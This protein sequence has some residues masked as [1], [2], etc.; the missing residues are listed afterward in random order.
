MAVIQSVVDYE[1][2]EEERKAAAMTEAQKLEAEKK[3][4][5]EER[6]AFE[7]QQ[8]AFVLRQATLGAA[9]RAGAIYP[10]V[11]DS[12]VLSRVDEVQFN[13]AREPQNVD[14]L[15]GA[16][17]KTH[18]YLFRAPAGSADGGAG[19][20]VAGRPNSGGMNEIIRRAAGRQG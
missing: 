17:R 5:E 15:V 3:R 2:A 16:I 10:D 11:I 7:H 20:G 4:L 1:K 18:P 13:E 14:A 12:M 8:R 9:G 6:V 19:G